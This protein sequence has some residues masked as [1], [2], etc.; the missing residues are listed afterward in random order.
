MANNAGVFKLPKYFQTRPLGRLSGDKPFLL[1]PPFV[2]V[3]VLK[4]DAYLPRATDFQ[5]PGE[6]EPQRA[7]SD[8][9]E[10]QSEH[11]RESY[12]YFGG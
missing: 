11:R 3:T 8:E 12:R 9:T 2:R 7:L 10:C 5:I 6:I 1:L 4:A